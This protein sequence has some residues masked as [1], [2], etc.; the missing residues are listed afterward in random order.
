MEIATVMTIDVTCIDPQESLVASHLQTLLSQ[1]H[2]IYAL[3]RSAHWQARGI[4]FYGDHQMFEKMYTPIIDEIDT[5]AERIVITFSPECV[6]ASLLYPVISEQIQSFT[7]DYECPFD[8]V[9]AA[10]YELISM[11]SECMQMIDEAEMITLG[12]EDFL[13]ELTSQ[14]EEHLYLLDARAH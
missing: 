12:W 8:R 5:L 4:S 7:R 6:D 11:I 1:L 2:T 14:H 9:Y 10:E 3:H 13:G